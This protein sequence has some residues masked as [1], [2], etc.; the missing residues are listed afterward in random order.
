MAIISKSDV[1]AAQDKIMRGEISLDQYIEIVNAYNQQLQTGMLTQRDIGNG[2]EPSDPVS[3]QPEPAPSTSSDR[4]YTYV[5]ESSDLPGGSSRD[6]WNANEVNTTTGHSGLT[7]LFNSRKEYQ[8]IFGSADNFI[9]YM[10]Q[11][12]D[13]Q[14]AN[15]ELYNWWETDSAEQFA[16]ANGY[17]P[18]AAYDGLEAA[19]Q[20]E[21]DREYLDYQ[22]ETREQQFINMSQSGDY[23]GLVEQFGLNDVIR[24]DDGDIFAFNGGFPVEI[25]EVDDHLGVDEYGR[26]ALAIGLS[27]YAGPFLS[28]ALA[29]GAGAVGTTLGAAA[30]GAVTSAMSQ[31]I[32]SGEIDINQMAEAALTAGV[33]TAAVNALRE[34]G[35]IEQ[36]TEWL[37]SQ[38]GEFVQLEDG[39]L[40]Q[41]NNPAL[42][43]SGAFAGDAWTVTLPSGAVLDYDVFLGL[44]ESVYGSP[45]VAEISRG[46]PDWLN[47]VVDVADPAFQAVSSAIEA[48]T[49]MS[50]GTGSGGVGSIVE[51]VQPINDT[52]TLVSQLEE[53]I[54][55]ARNEGDDEQAE[56]I[57]AEL[58]ALLGTDTTTD[59]SADTDPEIRQQHLLGWCCSW[60]FWQWCVHC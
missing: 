48:A 40:F 45:V 25:Y 3:P 12:Y 39:Q 58:D 31:L 22:I 2:L 49:S 34:A 51:N 27:L 7:D 13:L 44:A 36:V 29:P 16:D 60:N 32:I 8:Q 42:P 33:S 15:P 55:N 11:M 37:N 53:A 35:T 23:R 50:R 4:T 38:V 5:R 24:N 47:T 54:E 20:R 19:A 41:L 46:F 1:Y 30:S 17:P 6:I 18:E 14:Q 28:S 57:Q 52:T 21:F 9:S 56:A 59:D 43:D 26:I 10:D